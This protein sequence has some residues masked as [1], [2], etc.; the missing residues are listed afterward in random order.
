MARKCP[1]FVSV[2][3]SRRNDLCQCFIICL[4]ITT[5]NFHDQKRCS[6]LLYDGSCDFNNGVGVGETD[7]GPDEI[8]SSKRIYRYLSPMFRCSLF[9]IRMGDSS[10]PVSVAEVFYLD[11]LIK[12]AIIVVQIGSEIP[13]LCKRY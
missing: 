8:C 7:A 13:E 1:N 9:Y 4:Y 3:N 11:T 10:P 2:I 5:I 6:K 12:F